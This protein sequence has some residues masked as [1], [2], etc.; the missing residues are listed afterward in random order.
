MMERRPNTPHWQMIERTFR[1]VAG[2]SWRRAAA[3]ALGIQ[4]CYLRDLYDRVDITPAEIDHALECMNRALVA[5]QAE[6]AAEHAAAAQVR[7][8]V[9]AAQSVRHAEQRRL[10][11]EAL[12][13]DDYERYR[14]HY[15]RLKAELD[16]EAA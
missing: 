11:E 14:V 12:H 16:A 7:C 8:D 2:R 5:R 9:I 3:E 15:A 1:T 6:I 13:A 4:R 10:D